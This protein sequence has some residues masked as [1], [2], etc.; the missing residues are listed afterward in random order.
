MPSACHRGIDAM[1]NKLRIQGLL[2]TLAALLVL[3]SGCQTK[4]ANS[5]TVATYSGG[6]VTQASLYKELKQSPTTKTVLANLLIYRALDHAYGKSVS[7]K[8]VN[9]TYDSYQKQY[10][11]N[12]TS[13]LTQN[14]FSKASFR[15]SIRTNLLSEVALKKLKKVT[16]SQ[17]KEAWKTY[18]PKV[19]VQHILTSD[20]ATAKQVISD[21][22]A[23]KDFTTLAKTYSIDTAT[24]DNGGKT[25]FEATSKSFDSTFKDA[26][27]K[28][29][30]GDYTQSPVKVT[31]GYEVIKMV[32]HPAKG[33]FESNKEALTANVYAKWSRNSSVMQR[34][35]SQVL[36]DQ[37]VT[38]KDKDLSDALDSYKQSVAKD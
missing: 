31:N 10:G 17:L 16:N 25:S 15:Q 3:L 18:Q 12:F 7:T 21:L 14:G 28:L 34:V 13:F 33:S 38:I 6:Q 22:A 36:K 2:T 37:H 1:K 11:E 23:G 26:A 27:Y 5:S 32:N 4:Q 35:I 29:K 24:K 19:T 20:E 30:N 8:A 9:T